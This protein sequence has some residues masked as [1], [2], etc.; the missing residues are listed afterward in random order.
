MLDFL[1]TL[2]LEL[3]VSCWRV[4]LCLAVSVAIA[5]ALTHAFAG[6]TAGYCV[7]LALLGCGVGVVWEFR[8]Y[9]K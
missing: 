5:L 2:I 4:L 9:R 8:A 1:A 3:A 6:L 7:G